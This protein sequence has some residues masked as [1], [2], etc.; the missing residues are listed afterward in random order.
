MELT[1]SLGTTARTIVRG[2]ATA[3]GWR[4]LEYGPAEGRLEPAPSGEVVGCLWHL[5]DPHVCDCESP[6]RLEYLDRYS[7]PDSAYREELGDIGTYRP[8]EALTVHVAVTMVA[9]VNASTIGPTTAS[10]VDAVVITGD[11]TDNA[12]RNELDWYQAVLEGGT[13]APR[14]GG[15]GSSWVGATNSDAWDE[16][17]WHP[18]GSPAGFERDRPTRLFGYPTIPRLVEASRADVRSPGLAIPWLSV[19]G[20]HDGL[21]QGTVPVDDVLRELARGSARITGLPSGLMPRAVAE[22]I[23]E[24]GPARYLQDDTSPRIEIAPD[25]ARAFTASGEFAGVTRG[26]VGAPNYFVSD[27][28]DL[29]VVALDTINPHGGWQGSLDEEQ[30]DWLDTELSAAQGRYVVIASHHPSPTLVNAYAP[31]GAGPRVLGPRVVSLLLEHSNVIAWLA[32]HVHF[33]A[34]GYHGND[35]RGFWELTTASLIDWPQQGRI[36]E[37]VRVRDRG[38]PQI[39]IVSTVVDH[40]A[41]PQWSASALSDVANLASISR[42]LAANDYRLR[43]GSLRG[44]RLHSAPDVR[45][46]VWRAPD[47]AGAISSWGIVKSMEGIMTET[48]ENDGIN[49]DLAAVSDGA[50]TLIVADFDDVDAAWGAYELLKSVEDG[51]TLA[52]ESVVVVKRGADGKIDVQKATD[53]STGKGLAWGVVGGVVLGVIFPPSIIGSAIVLGAAG[54]GAGKLAKVHHNK[55][56][57]KDLEDAIEPGHSGIIALV[58]DPGVVEIRKALEK[59]NRVV[60]SAVDDVVA[61]DIKAAAKEAESEAKSEG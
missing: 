24:V 8:Q 53:H 39:A 10:P 2:S 33:H 34:A 41:P 46:V 13:I 6:A 17:Y 25:P 32:G 52:I 15:Q 22:A 31:T 43:A 5:S 1:G 23:S 7:D 27:L 12:Q 30:L 36:L 44:L 40:G 4:M 49:A 59:A 16:R 50:F 19:Y 45:N 58:S 38:R 21:A 3:A 37:F 18:D 28:G 54:A 51:R 47:P 48:T 20:N 29:R 61:K 11:L 9:T 26:H 56:I 55:E 42:S 60:E 57:A 14:S 35:Q